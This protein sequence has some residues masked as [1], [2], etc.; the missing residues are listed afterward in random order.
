MGDISDIFTQ[1]QQKPEIY[2]KISL[3]FLDS[4]EYQKKD[5]SKD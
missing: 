5:D 2:F 1:Y 3:V 4:S